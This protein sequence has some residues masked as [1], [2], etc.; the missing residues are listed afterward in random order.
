MPCGLYMLDIGQ[1]NIISTIATLILALL[2]SVKKLMIFIEDYQMLRSKYNKLNFVLNTNYRL[3]R[4]V[5]EANHCSPLYVSSK[6]NCMPS[7]Y[8][9]STSISPSRL[10]PSHMVFN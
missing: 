9:E 4:L 2:Q 8:W 7:A 1:I 5:K 6:S 3:T 10:S